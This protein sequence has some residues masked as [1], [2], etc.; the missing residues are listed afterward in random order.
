MSDSHSV[1]DG[2]DIV[3]EMAAWRTAHPTA[4]LAEIEAALD[5]RL[6]AVRRQLLATTI[7]Q[8]TDATW[9]HQPPAQRPVCPDCGTPLVPRGTHT[10]TM[11]SAGGDVPITRTYG[12]CPSCKRGLFPPR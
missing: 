8:R 10:R 9:E 5:A 6:F 12:T 7:A 3:T 1:P 11:H 2:V 4:T